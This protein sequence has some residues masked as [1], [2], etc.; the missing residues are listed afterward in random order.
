MFDSA[1]ATVT[2]DCGHDERYGERLRNATWR[3][4]RLSG[5]STLF[6]DPA[7][8][9]MLLIDP[10]GKIVRVMSAP[11]AGDVGFLVGGPFG[12]PGFD[13]RDGS[14]IVLRHNFMRAPPPPGGG[15]PDDA[16]S[17]RFGRARPL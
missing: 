11:R 3:T 12:N 7:S 16:F 9:S 10:N 15:M 14:C 17:S 1:L 5:D 13:R 2:V 6:I 8:L 4:D